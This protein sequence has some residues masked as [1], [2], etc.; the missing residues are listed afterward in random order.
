MSRFTNE[1]IKQEMHHCRADFTYFCKKYITILHP[2]KGFIR[3]EL[4][5]FQERIAKD[6]IKHR[7]NIIQKPRQMG[8]ST[9]TS[10]YLLWLALF[11]PAKEIMIISIGARESKEFL[12]H[13]KVA[14][15][16]LPPWLAGKLVQDNK[17]T[18]VFD[19]DSRIQSIPSPKYA[20]RSFSASILVIDEAA[21]IAPIDS[22]WTSAFPILSTG[23][24]AIVLSTVNGTYG[25]GQW[26]FQ[27]WTEAELKLNHFNPISL[28]YTEHPEYVVEGWAEGQRKNLGD[29]KFEQEVLC[30][31]LGSVSTFISREIIQKYL[32]L[33]HK[34][35]SPLKEPESKRYTDMLWIWE[36]P[37]PDHYYIMGIDTAK[38]GH[39]KSNSTFQII[40]VATGEQVVEFC[41]KLDT[42]EYAKIVKV[43]ATEYNNAYVVLEINNMGL[44][45]MNELHINLHYT[46]V[47][48]RKA[49]VPGWE[50]TARTR[51]FIIQSI[52]QIFNKEILKIYSTRIIN[53]LQTFAADPET[54]KIAKQQ[55]STDDLLIA[56]GLAYMG[57]QSAIMSNPA[58]AAMFGQN[59]EIDRMTLNCYVELKEE[60]QGVPQGTKGVVI[61]ITEKEAS[62]SF[63]N[64]GVFKIKRENLKLLKMFNEYDVVRWALKEDP[65]KMSVKMPDGTTA[66]EDFRWLVG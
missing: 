36:K 37:V 39:G 26:F 24:A 47:Y 65:Y 2:N 51:P 22:L 19:N 16:R 15:E 23:G 25:T 57:M 60:T 59:R 33:E 64:T 11:N 54:G 1:Y 53:E 48:Y 52:E 20:A 5:K 32:D 44:A 27:K 9:L 30:N 17:S 35:I 43:I 49:G 50:T 58:L 45:V 28:H 14:H 8:L 66:E 40:D 42:V 38:Q 12:K 46:N 10:I 21:F 6:Y 31:F 62:V 7:F 34:G 3:F 56:L 18:M 55:G 4:Y 61:H 29:Q 41:G 63:Q 13:I